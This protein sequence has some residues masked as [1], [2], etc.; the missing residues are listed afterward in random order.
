ML[1]APREFQGPVPDGA[2]A[3]DTGATAFN[4]DIMPQYLPSLCRP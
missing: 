2:V 3:M 1:A 4:T